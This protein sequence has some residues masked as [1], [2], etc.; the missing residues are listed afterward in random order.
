MRRTPRASASGCAAGLRGSLAFG[1]SCSAVARTWPPAQ[2]ASPDGIATLVA[3]VANANQKLQDLGAAIQTQQESVN[4]A[5]V[6][7]QTARDNA[8]AAQPRSTPAR[9]VK[10][11]NTAI[12]AAQQRFDT[13]AAVDLHER[14]VASYVTATDPADILDTAATGQT[15]ADQLAAGDRRSAA[16]P[17][18]AGQPGVGGPAGQAEGRPGRRRRAGQPGD[19]RRRR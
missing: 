13:F 4:K 7:V 10:D 9:R 2:P 5:I 8:A 15:L 18:R 11:A 16:G 12:A 14:T 6:D 1:M 17:Y 19:R 3:E